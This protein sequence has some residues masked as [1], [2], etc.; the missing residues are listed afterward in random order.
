[1]SDVPIILDYADRRGR[2]RPRFRVERSPEAVMLSKALQPRPFLAMTLALLAVAAL[3]SA[4][5]G[6]V[7]ALDDLPHEPGLLV[8][9]VFVVLVMP[10]I[11]F[12]L[13]RN[14]S[15]VSRRRLLTLALRRGTLT[16]GHAS[17]TLFGGPW[18]LAEPGRFY[19][20]RGGTDL[21]TRRPLGSVHVQSRDGH[22]RSV[23]RQFPPDECQ[24][25]VLQMNDAIEHGPHG[26]AD[27]RDE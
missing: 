9:H 26:L 16:A 6:C 11:A 23:L 19:V 13:A 5:I 10:V 1:M 2:L 4:A 15:I 18:A 3:V 8:T 17:D 24:W 20:V 21:V 12:G 22:G 7:E 14:A 27:Q 25:V